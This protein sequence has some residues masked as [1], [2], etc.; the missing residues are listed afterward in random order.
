MIDWNGIIKYVKHN[1][2][3]PSGFIEKADEDIREYLIENSLSEFSNYYPDKEYAPILVDN[4]KYKHPTRPWHYLI[5][6]EENLSIYGIIQCY[7]DASVDFMGGH[8]LIGPMSFEGMKWFALS[9]FKS[10]FLYPYSNWRYDYHFVPPNM[11][12]VRQQMQPNNFVVQYERSHPPDL[13][14]IPGA[15]ER[16]FKELCLSDI[17]IWI[18]N[19]RNM[20][21]S[22]RTPYGDLPINGDAM[23]SEGNEKKRNILE[24]FVEDSRPP[25]ILD[26]M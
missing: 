16:I 5:I 1:I 12:R 23:K 26:V 2:G 11:I 15:M 6:D 21:G 13:R 3:L 25:F 10:N 17:M 20:Y 4:P 22:L 24:R 9:A 7:F 14:R 19:I 8:P 18:G